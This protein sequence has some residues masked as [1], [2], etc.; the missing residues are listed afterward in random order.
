VRR[1]GDDIAVGH[2]IRVQVRGHQAGD[3]GHVH[4]QPR[5][6]F[7]GDGAHA[8]EVPEARI[9]A[10]AGHDQLGFDLQR[11]PLHLVV[12]DALG[13]A[14][15]AI[16]VKVVKLARTVELHAVGQMAAVV[17]LEAEHRVAGVE[18][19]QVDRLVGLRAGVGLHVGVVGAENLLGAGD[20]DLFR[21]VHILAAAVIALVGVAFGVFVGEDAAQGR[22]HGRR[23]IVL[24]GDQLDAVCLAAALQLDCLIH[25]RVARRQQLARVG[26]FCPSRQ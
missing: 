19:R 16:V 12:V 4:H 8:R 1:G 14:R 6:D 17:E 5:A 18:Q 11:E 7:V 25:L 15:H 10:G 3:V 24:A 20:G 2:G 26:H 21:H 22:Q 23:H 13:V 9:G